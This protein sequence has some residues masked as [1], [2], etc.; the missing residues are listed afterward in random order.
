MKPP[1]FT[2][3]RPTDVAQAVATLGEVGARGKVLAGG[4]SLVPLMSMRL[5]E[6]AH[7]VDIGRLPGLDTVEVTSRQ[8]RVGALVRHADLERHE[9][10]HA[11]NPVLRQA[12]RHVAH[13]TI[14][15]RGTSVGSLCHADAA[16]EMPAVLALLGGH[17]VAVSTAGEREVPVDEL[18]V[19]P[20]ETS[21][22]P[23]EVVTAAAFP[24]PEGCVG[25]SVV[26]VARRQGDY[27]VCGVVALVRLAEDGSLDEAR[28]AYVSVADVPPVLDLTEAVRG[29][30]PD[31]DWAP[32]GEAAKERLECD[33]DI[34]VSAQYR[35][36]LV[37]VLTERALREAATR[38]E[39]G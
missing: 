36:H 29:I 9:E 5:A 37:G 35:H 19:G 17:V 28:A 18:Y 24:V 27:A 22:R 39:A 16:A 26:E 21:L 2:Y 25:T 12:L 34:H 11:A 10:A 8:V 31:G 7:L 32:A 13:P 30:S 3:H 38:A 33:G 23:D 6:P 15:N 4:Q 20:L 14:R 1:P